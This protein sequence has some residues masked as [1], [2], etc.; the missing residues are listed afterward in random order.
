MAHCSHKA[1][2]NILEY[3]VSLHQAIYKLIDIHTILG[4]AL[5]DLINAKSANFAVGRRIDLH[6]VLSFGDFWENIRGSFVPILFQVLTISVFYHFFNLP[7]ARDRRAAPVT[8]STVIGKYACHVLCNLQ[9]DE[10][11]NNIAFHSKH[12]TAGT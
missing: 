2:Q 7:L 10:I 1:V 11:K 12:N 8:S 5:L 3:Y 6:R 4:L 9:K